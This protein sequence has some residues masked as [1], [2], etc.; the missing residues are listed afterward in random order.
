MCECKHSEMKKRRSL[1]TAPPPAGACSW[2]HSARVAPRRYC[3]LSPPPP[4]PPRPLPRPSP[5]HLRRPTSPAPRR[6]PRGAPLACARRAAARGH[7]C[8]RA[9]ARLESAQIFSA[10]RVRSSAPVRQRCAGRKGVVVLALRPGAALRPPPPSYRRTAGAPAHCSVLGAQKISAH[11]PTA[12]ARARTRA[13]APQHA[14][15]KRGAPREGAC[16]VQEKLVA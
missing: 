3:P 2:R 11:S 4:P 13:R 10:R 9:R 8:A 1:P 7:G 14:A 16:A 15:H 5:P 6:L 12:R